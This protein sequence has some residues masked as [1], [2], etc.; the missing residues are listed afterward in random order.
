M[1]VLLGP[2]GVITCSWVTRYQSAS[3]VLVCSGFGLLVR[4]CEWSSWV[5]KYCFLDKNSLIRTLRQNPFLMMKI[6]F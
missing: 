4:R 2:I 3:P 5:D 6:F 1:G